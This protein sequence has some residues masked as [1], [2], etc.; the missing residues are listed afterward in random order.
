MGSGMA[1]MQLRIMSL[2]SQPVPLFS[3]NPLGLK[4]RAIALWS[5]Q[6]DL[7]LAL[8]DLQLTTMTVSRM[9]SLALILAS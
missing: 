6:L 9:P 5:Y 2:M 1:D 7:H 4:V 3:S 8:E